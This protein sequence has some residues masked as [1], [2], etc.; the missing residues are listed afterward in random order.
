MPISPE[1]A[2]L[3]PPDWPEISARIRERDGNRC[4]W[5]GAAN[6]EPHPETGSMVVITVAHLDHDPTN[7]DER[8]LAALCQRCHLR[9]D[10]REHARHAAETRRQKREAAGQGVLL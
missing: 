5:C 7:R 4:A 1:R 3:Y 8:N 6:H 2:A 10:A 9:Y